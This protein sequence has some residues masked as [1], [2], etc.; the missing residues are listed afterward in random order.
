MSN[1]QENNSKKL[2][3]NLKEKESVCT[4]EINSKNKQEDTIELQNSIEHIV[5]DK[6]DIILNILI[7]ILFILLVGLIS[8][9]I[10]EKICDFSIL[11]YLIDK[12]S[13]FLIF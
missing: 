2:K 5:K 12:I 3:F 7:I 1:V 10:I 4:E 8:I 13:M 9:V 11:E 6:T